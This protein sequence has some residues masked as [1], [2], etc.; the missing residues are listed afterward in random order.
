ML[1]RCRKKVRM[2]ENYDKWKKVEVNTRFFFSRE[3]EG[4]R[5]LK[6]NHIHIFHLYSTVSFN[7]FH[8]SV[9]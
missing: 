2:T 8:L 4:D 6:K 3:K 9:I 1:Q 7:A 5:K